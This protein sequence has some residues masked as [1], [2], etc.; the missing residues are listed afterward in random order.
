M[1]RD[2]PNPRHGIS[3]SITFHA[4]ELKPMYGMV[5][6]M[7]SQ[8]SPTPANDFRSGRVEVAGGDVAMF[9]GNVPKARKRDI[10]QGITECR[11]RHREEAKG[12]N[13]VETAGIAITV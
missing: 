8:R 10:E 5:A 2:L 1:A 11:E 7:P 13:G 3:A 6:N 12:A 4:D 9:R